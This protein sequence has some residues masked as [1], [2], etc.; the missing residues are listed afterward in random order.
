MRLVL[1]DYFFRNNT[2]FGCG[3]NEINSIASILHII[4]V[5]CKTVV[6]ESLELI[7]QQ[8]SHIVDFYVDFASEIFKV[9]GHLPIVG[10]RN[11]REVR[12]LF[13]LFFNAVEGTDEPVFLFNPV[14]RGAAVEGMCLEPNGVFYMV[15]HVNFA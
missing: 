11:D 6:V 5:R 4:G 3:Y 9:E 2:F 13:G 14:F 12:K 10:I 15:E 1:N 8:A 7:N